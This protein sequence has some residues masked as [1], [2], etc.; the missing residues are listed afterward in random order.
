MKLSIEELAD[1]VNK[2]V[3]EN[4]NSGNVKDKR[5]SS[6]LST[7]RIRDYITKGLINKPLGTKEKWFD[8][9]H[10]QSLLSLRL[11]Q[12]NGLSEQYIKSSS[13]DYEVPKDDGNLKNDALSF[14]NSLSGSAVKGREQIPTLKPSIMA[15]IKLGEEAQSRGFSGAVASSLSSS[16]LGSSEMMNHVYAKS[17]ELLNAFS[18]SVSQYNQ[19]NEY[20]VDKELGVYLKVDSKTNSDLQVKLCEKIKEEIKNYKGEKND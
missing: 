17:S 15:S 1:E 2:L 3:S 18:Q 6:V 9:T 16:K 4:I 19:Y 12:L 10:V 5:Q 13:L 11:L 20:C 7:R 8:E 14:L